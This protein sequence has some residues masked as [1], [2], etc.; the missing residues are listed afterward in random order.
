MLK[1]LMSSGILLLLLLSSSCNDE[2]K[3]IQTWTFD[4]ALFNQMETEWND[5]KF[6]NYSFKYSVSDVIS[7]A[8]TGIVT[9]TDGT[10][11]V[12]LSVNGLNSD[13]EG[14]EE[15]LNRYAKRNIRIAFTSVDELYSY[16]KSVVYK[17]L[18]DYE[19]KV[20]IIYDL[21]IAYD[22][23][24]PVPSLIEE[25][26]FYKDDFI[27]ENKNGIWDGELYIKIEDFC[28]GK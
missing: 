24:N 23:D 18:Q 1:L 10:G 16:I 19:S 25:T 9:V 15:E 28:I 8:V 5:K 2:V 11:S 26:L 27:D 7:D 6:D 17:R 12:E 14:Y 3:L 4:E 21:K 13:D 22:N 20:I